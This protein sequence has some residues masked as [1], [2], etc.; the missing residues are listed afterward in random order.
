VEAERRTVLEL[1]ERVLE[2][3]PVVEDLLGRE[4]RLERRLVEAAE[5]AE[6]VADLRLLR[7]ELRVV[8]E[9]LKPAAA[10][11]RV[12]R[13]R[14]LDALRSR[15]EDLGRERLRVVPLHLRHARLD[16]VAREAAA[17]E[18]HEA[19]EPRDPV[20]A[21]REG[22]DIELELLVLR[23]RRGHGGQPSGVGR[24][25]GVVRNHP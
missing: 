1:R 14:R 18:D 25:R 20:P 11:S 24:F 13:A 4:N 6:R 21:V 22:V 23:Y 19:V 17:D 12:V 9:V 7:G 8:R 5:P 15:L 3:V 16:P 10:A 2:L